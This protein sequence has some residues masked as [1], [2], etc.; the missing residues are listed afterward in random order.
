LHA[1]D[2]SWRRVTELIEVMNN[3]MPQRRFA[4]VQSAGKR[5]ITHSFQSNTPNVSISPWAGQSKYLAIFFLRDVLR[6]PPGGV[7]DSSR[8]PPLQEG[9]CYAPHKDRPRRKN[10]SSKSRPLTIPRARS[11]QLGR[12]LPG[13]L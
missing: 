3:D 7:F 1:R 11:A 13:G 5:L 9:S 2:T 10:G 12:L 8:P 4:S 6:E